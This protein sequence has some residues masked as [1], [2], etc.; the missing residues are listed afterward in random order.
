LRILLEEP[1]LIGVFSELCRDIVDSTR[2]G[3]DPTRAGSIILSRIERWRA[4]FL[5]DSAGLDRF[6]LR[7]LIGE[8]LVLERRLIEDL[9]IDEAV[10]AW[11]GPPGLAQDFRLP[12]GQRIEVKAV[13]RDAESV[14]V[15]G[16]A[17]LDGGDDPL[18][19]AVVR[20]EETGRDAPG[21]LT[22]SALVGRL[23]TRLIDSPTALRSFNTLLG[24]VGWD[25]DN[26]GDRVI[27]RLVR[28]DEYEVNATFPRLTP[29]TV[30]P[31]VADATYKIVL[32]GLVTG[33]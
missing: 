22:A 32:P 25:D 11:T 2:T 7:G 13:D 31:G 4:L 24:F 21:A 19:L 26:E 29:G 3:I 16:L 9:G 1:K 18:R 20:L 28:I 30:P 8:L 33:Q 6:A 10:A 15:N 5:A 23:R 14:T 12:S 27:V 17:Q